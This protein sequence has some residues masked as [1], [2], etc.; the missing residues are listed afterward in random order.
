MTKS[1]VVAL[2]LFTL[3]L[4]SLTAGQ[5]WESFQVSA[6]AGASEI[7][8]NGFLAFPVVGALIA[9]QAVLVLVSL[10][11]RPFI[12]RFMAAA[13]AG[14]M[15]WNFIDVLDTFA[16][17]TQAAFES[18]LTEQTGVIANAS[19]SEFLVAS[20]GGSLQWAYLACVA[21]NV[22]ILLFVSLVRLKPNVRNKETTELFLP[23][24]LWSRQS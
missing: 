11:V 21:L 19:G 3:L 4:L 13:V 20:S 2:W 14:L 9:L 8:I 15:V 5:T 7:Q 24:D 22:L 1:R 10:L 17:R 6:E 16:V 12:I 18:I 23:E